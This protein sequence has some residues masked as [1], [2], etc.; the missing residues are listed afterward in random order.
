MARKKFW[1]LAL[2]ALL[3]GASAGGC[4]GSIGDSGASGSSGGGTVGPGGSILPGGG[5]GTGNGSSGNGSTGNGGTGTG[6]GSGNGSGSIGGGSSGAP[7]DP[8]AAGPMPLRR[9]TSR[10]YNNTVR[11]LLGDTSNPA[12]GFPVDHDSDFLFRRAGIVSTTDLDSLKD[13]AEATAAGVEAK[14]TTLAPCSGAEDACAKKFINDFGLRAYRRP[15]VQEEIDRLMALYTAGR[16][17]LMLNYAGAIR[18]IVEGM[19]QSPAF[20]YHWELGYEKPTVEGD[21]VKL[22]PYENASRLSYFIWG[23]MPDST[24]FDAA[25]ANKLGTPE[26]LTAQAKRMLGDAKARDTVTSFA[27]EWLNLDTITDRPKDPMFYPEYND[28]LKAAMTSELQSFIT[29]VVFDGDGSFKTLLQSTGSYVNQA[30]GTLYGVQ[31]VQ[32]AAMKQASLNEAE[33]AG[34]LT[35]AGFLTITAVTNASSPVKRGHKVYD[36]FMCGPLPSPPNNVPPA[37]PPTAAGTTRQHFE[38]HDKNPCTG[39]CHKLMDPLGFA[40]EHYDGIGKYRDME[41]GIQVDSTGSIDLDGGSHAFK[42][43]RELS[44]ILAESPTVSRCFA[45]EWLRYA[46]KRA[47][48]DADNASINQALDS[49]G[50]KTSVTDLIVSLVGSR[51]F[52]YRTPGMGENLQ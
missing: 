52:R 5:A 40:F 18:L 29:N 19:L 9:L 51:T 33:R 48:V 24:L 14:A 23:S 7:A 13:A 22:N 35:R 50:Q 17:T 30:L 39:A 10:E 44:K 3:G 36:R 25:A 8:N 12:N 1:A 20:L 31:G 38:E 32:G 26:E 37:K 28:A 15:V 11:D 21:Y 45:T 46:F 41:N 27:T 43:A 16:G 6:N 49:F 47:E 34:L 4:N 42:D 2:S